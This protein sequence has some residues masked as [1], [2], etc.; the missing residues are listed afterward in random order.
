MYETNNI[1]IGAFMKTLKEMFPDRDFTQMQIDFFMD[2]LRTMKNDK[3]TSKI[4]VMPYRCGIGKSTLLQA[5]IQVSLDQSDYGMI[6]V[7]DRVNRLKSLKHYDKTQEQLDS[8][9]WINLFVNHGDKISVL[10]AEHRDAVLAEQRYKPILMMTTQRFFQMDTEKLKEFLE[11]QTNGEK[12][13]RK[14]IIFD[15]EPYLQDIHKIQ[16][17]ELH[18]VISALKDGIDDTCVQSVK[19]WAV[20]QFETFVKKLEE[21]LKE[22]EYSRSKNTYS[23][24]DYDGASMTE[25]DDKFLKIIE[26]YKGSIT[27]RN[28]FVMQYIQD[29]MNI[30]KHGALLTVTKV[31]AGD[32][33]D[34]TFLV[35][36]DYKDHLLLDDDVKTFVLDG[37]ADISAKYPDFCDYVNIKD[38]SAFNVPMDY[39]TI[40]IVHVNTSRNALI[41]KDKDGS[42]KEIIKD[43]IRSR[44]QN[45]NDTL[46]VS[47][48]SLI[49]DGCFNGL[50]NQTGY[51][52]NLRGYN[53]YK[54]AHNYIQIGVNRQ[55]DINYLALLFHQQ[56]EYIDYMR[57]LDEEKRIEFIDKIIADDAIKDI[58]NQEVSSDTIQNIYRIAVRDIGNT[59]PINV[60]LF[61]DTKYFSTVKGNL[62]ETFGKYGAKLIDENIPQ[63]TKAK[64][65]NRS[66]VT[67]NKSVAQKVIDWI[68][69]LPDDEEF[70]TAEICKGIGINSKQLQKA[71]DNNK[72]LKDLLTAMSVKRGTFRKGYTPC[73][74]GE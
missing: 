45:A 7:T 29:C 48:M 46:L 31:K 32:N 14:M 22:Y 19:D 47:Y 68:D 38:C 35:I 42:L 64:I 40:H 37:T 58:V 51:F 17:E 18:S 56:P 20:I 24:F 6:I 55:R 36:K 39:M 43:Y 15:E 30:V 50:A 73:T 74:P 2:C 33:F 16:S 63:L 61:F 34:R 54:D 71:K 59:E 53:I 9:D 69:N 67:G 21:T 52:G 66:S 27:R 65:K 44:N 26:T 25:N 60:Y 10:D 70:T 72:G 4:T 5:Y 8:D 41:S 1:D 57:H 62:Y 23:W 3:D 13:K 12:K 11:Y 49:T 28:R